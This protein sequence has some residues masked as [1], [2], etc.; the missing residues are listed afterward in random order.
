LFGVVIDLG[1]E[2]YKKR[3][4]IKT[5]KI[6]KVPIS[7]FLASISGLHIYVNDM[8]QLAENIHRVLMR[9]SYGNSIRK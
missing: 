5:I 9:T 4:R 8:I 7:Q 3:P 6:E 2:R 1:V